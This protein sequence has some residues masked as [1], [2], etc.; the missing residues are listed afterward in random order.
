M[1]RLGLLLGSLL[2][3][4]ACA[5]NPV[6]GKKELSFVSEEWELNIGAQQYAPSRQSQGGDYLADPH[7][8]A[9]VNKIG[10]RVASVSDRKLPYEFK[11]INSSVPN[12]WAL[13]GGKIAINRG[14]LTELSSEAELAAVLGHEVVHA[15]AKH[16]AK[17]VTRG[18][19]LQG[20]VL[21]ATIATS[22]KKYAN[23]A[24]AASGIGAQLI[25]TRYGRDAERESDRFGIEY[26]VRAGYDPQG[27]VDL[28]QTFLD[29][30]KDQRRQDFITGLFAS[31]PPSAERL[32]NNKKLAA[33]FDPG[34]E[35]GR[36][37]YQQNLS[38]LFE[39]AAA[40]KAYDEA[41]EAASEKDIATAKSL[42]QRAIR[43]EPNEGHFHSFL[44][45][46]ELDANNPRGA[47]R[48]Y[49]SAIRANDGFFYYHLQKGLASEAV[50]DYRAANA[51]LNRSLELLPTANAH[52]ALG[53]IAK[54][55]GRR[56]EAI[57]Q[58]SKAAVHNS[59][60][61]QAAMGSLVDLDLSSNPG[62]YIATRPQ[63]SENGTVTVLIQNKTPRNLQ[64]VVLKI[65]YP[66]SGGNLQELTRRISGTLAA[67]K[68]DQLSVG[69]TINPEFASSLKSG[70][71]RAEVSN[72]RS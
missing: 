51:S 64:G 69:I 29:L 13:P 31:H 26:M 43:I 40:Y 53:N 3:L 58:Y 68:T 30:S 49:N 67:G 15:A 35:T 16:G 9:Y 28:Q 47:I 62:K 71:V 27:A 63:I 37:S 1:K 19:L 2:A 60:A 36:E 18:V 41:R 54:I 34:G 7:V 11:V 12:A 5:T 48:H 70:V 4:S 25:S 17:G 66:D 55:G 44:G 20:G 39:T 50:Q 14:L 65:I 6:T 45:D 61:G 8:Q 72:R 42:V 33:T 46:I 38:H 52:N 59:P 32:Q 21:A 57:A 24:Q 56:D 10:Q 22:G 23:A